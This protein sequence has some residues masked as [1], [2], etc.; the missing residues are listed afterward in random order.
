MVESTELTALPESRSALQVPYS[1]A[2][3]EFF[4]EKYPDQKQKLARV[5]ER[6]D[7][8]ALD[9]FR[10]YSSER[11]PGVSFSYTKFTL[12]KNTLFELSGIHGKE[13]E[14]NQP[15]KDFFLFIAASYPPG[16]HPFWS[17]DMAIDRYIRCLPSLAGAFKRGESIPQTNIYLL[18]VPHGFGGSVTPDWLETVKNRGF[19]SQAKLYADF[20]TAC[21]KDVDT[22]LVLQGIS[23]G[24]VVAEKTSKFLPQN[25][26]SVTQRLLDNP[27]GYHRGKLKG[28]Q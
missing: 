16:G 27:I 1:E 9:N 2:A 6:M 18:G 7:R 3:H 4:G 23:K 5:L 15:K 25:L 24:A 14:E 12:D 17:Y 13:N 11:F 10:V 19:E 22:H 28:V 20:I 21:E 26:Q 8:D